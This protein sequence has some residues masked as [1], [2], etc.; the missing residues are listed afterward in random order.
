MTR[1]EKNDNLTLLVQRC[2]KILYGRMP[3]VIDAVLIWNKLVQSEDVFWHL[4]HIVGWTVQCLTAQ[5]RNVLIYLYLLCHVLLYV[6]M[7]GIQRQSKVCV[8]VCVCVWPFALSAQNVADD[9]A[10]DRQNNDKHDDHNDDN[11]TGRRRRAPPAWFTVTCNIAT[12][13]VRTMKNETETK[14]LQNSFETVLFRFR[15]VVRTVNRSKVAT[16]LVRSVRWRP[17]ARLTE[18]LL[19]EA[20]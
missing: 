20:I 15:F 16:H 13:T 10:D 17:M 3:L 5:A 8:C 2:L 6:T 12:K 9:G 4:D 1:S 11:D 7:T 19:I 18:N 14:Q